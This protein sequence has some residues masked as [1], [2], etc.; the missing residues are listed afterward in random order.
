MTQIASPHQRPRHHS[1]WKL[2]AC[3]VASSRGTTCCTRARCRGARSRPGVRQ[4]R[5]PSSSAGSCRVRRYSPGVVAGDLAER[6]RA[7]DEA[8]DGTQRRRRDRA[9]AR[10][11][12]L[13]STPPAADSRSG[14]RPSGTPRVSAVPDDDYLGLQPAAQLR[15]IVSRAHATSRRD[16]RIAARDAWT[17]FRS[18]DPR[19]LV[20][21]LPRFTVLPHLGPRLRR[22][23]QQF[24]S[25]ENGLSRTEQQAMEALAS[26]VTRADARLRRRHHR[27]E[28]AFFMGDAGFLFH[29][30]ALL[31]GPQPLLL[32]A[33]AVVMAASADADR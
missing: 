4:V 28:E 5:A 25:V 26:G 6:D 8:L 12:S 23:L 2:R 3:P 24:P 22:H 19:A 15:E 16:Q 7:L 9:V 33:H 27:R 14:R 1:G 10:V 18:P 21:A 29:M 20:D 11:R 30:S 13:R 17:A 32:I 31:R